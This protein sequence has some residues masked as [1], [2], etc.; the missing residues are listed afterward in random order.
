M[1]LPVL[2]SPEALSFWNSRN[3]SEREPFRAAVLS[4]CLLRATLEKRVIEVYDAPGGHPIALVHPCL[5][6]E[7][8]PGCNCS[9]CSCL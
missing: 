7:P 6:L 3:P 4:D 2:L 5:E 9:P 1:S 8:C